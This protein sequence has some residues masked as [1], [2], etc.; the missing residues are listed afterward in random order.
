MKKKLEITLIPTRL[1]STPRMEFLVTGE[2]CRLSVFYG[3]IAATA[4]LS[5]SV[6]RE[7]L[8]VNE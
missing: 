6:Q 7:V 3:Y 1:A 4:R 8:L 5:V 2:K